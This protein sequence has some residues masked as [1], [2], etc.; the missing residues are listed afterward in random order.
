MPLAG[1]LPQVP[2]VGIARLCDHQTQCSYNKSV[3]AKAGAAGAAAG[4]KAGA[5]GF[6]TGG[7]KK[8]F[9]AGG[10]AGAAGF[11]KGEWPLPD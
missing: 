4:G 2:K 3:G 7:G 8:G 6:A 11:K 5:A 9:A 10:A 1:P